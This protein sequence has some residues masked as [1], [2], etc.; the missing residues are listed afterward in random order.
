MTRPINPYTNH[1]VGSD[2]SLA[3]S[4]ENL[5]KTINEEWLPKINERRSDP[6]LRAADLMRC[7]LALTLVPLAKERCD[8]PELRAKLDE[9]SEAVKRYQDALLVEPGKAQA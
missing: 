2:E 9:T 6:Q 8:S 3:Q 4:C 7:S 5:V 1:P